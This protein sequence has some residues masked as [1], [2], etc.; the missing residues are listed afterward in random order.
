MF[1]N[2][3]GSKFPAAVLMMLAIAGVA[4]YAA[5]VFPVP[6][7][8]FIS[9][10]SA[11]P[12]GAQFTL[13]VNGANFVTSSTKSI[14]YWNGS[15]LVTRFVNSNQLT[16]VVPPGLIASG[17]TALVTVV[18][19]GCLG[20][21]SLS[22]NVVYL[23]IGAP[24]STL[25]VAA[26]SATVGSSPFE[27]TAADVNQDG[28]LDL[29]VS[30]LA[31][32]S[33]SILLGNG[34]GTFQPQT[35]FSTTVSGPF[36]IAIGDLNG[37]GIPDLVIGSD[38]TGLNIALGSAGGTYSVTS[39]SGG[40]CPLTPVLADVNHDGKLDIVVGNNCGNGIQVYFGNGDG[41][42][43][44]ATGISGSSQVSNLVVADLNG[45]GN[46]DVAAANFNLGTIDVYSGTG[47]GTFSPVSHVSAVSGARAIA[48]AD[49]DGDGK[50][51]LIVGSLTN[52]GI[53]FLHGNG[54]GTFQA[55]SS[56]VASGGFDSFAAGDMNTDGKMDFASVSA[57]G[58]VQAWLGNGDGTFQKPQTLGTGGGYGIALGNFAT[59]G[60]LSTAV[61]TGSGG[62]T[63][64]VYLQT[65]SLSPSSENFGSVNVG[66]SVQQIFTLTNSTS[67]T[68]GVSSVSF[69]GSDT[70]DFSQNNT[71][72]APLVPAAA[73]TVTVTFTPAAAGVRS[74]TLFISDS[75]PGSPQSASLS[76]TGV[77]VPL[78][79]LS[80]PLLMFGSQDLNV[81]SSPMPLS[82]SNTGTAA[83][84]GITISLTGTNVS[85]FAQTNNCPNSL[86]ASASCTVNVT[87]TPSAAGACSATL[88][89]TDNAANS[90]QTA[91]LNGTGAL[92]AAQLQFVQG[93]P[94]S[95]I[96]GS[97]IGML[98]VGVYTAQSMLATTSTAN[99][100]VTVTGP[101]SFHSSQTQATSS[102]V[103]AFNFNSPLTIAGQY[104]I[105]AISSELSSV[106]AN[107]T[108][109][110]QQSSAQMNVT[111]FPSPT[112]SG[113]P[114][115]FT[116]S[117]T[118]QFLNPITSYTGTMTLSSTDPSSILTPS[119][120]SFVAA[121]LGAH[122]FTGTLFTLGTQVI[123]ATDGQ[124]N[125]AQAG[126]QVN[127]RPQFVINTL[128]DDAGTA[129][130]DGNEPCSLR[131]AIAQSN[132]LGAGDI[133]VDTSQF[134]GALPFTSTLTNGVL[135]L[136]S[137]INITGPGETQ[138]VI[139]GKNA[140]NVFLVDVSAIATISSLTVTQGKSAGNGGA[141]SN[142]GTLA[143]SNV[144]VTNSAAAASGGG[145]YNSGNLTVSSSTISGNSAALN[146]GG[147][148]NGGTLAFYDSTISA[149]S[150]AGNGGGIDTSGTLSVPQSTFAANTAVDGAAIENEPTGLFTL[151]QS[152]L[153]GNTA[154]GNTG[155]SVS[156]QNST[157]G[158]ATIFE[159]IIAGNTAGGGDCLNCGTQSNFNLFGVIAATLN[160]APL[161]GNGGPTPTMVPLPGSP[162]IGAGSIE[163][164]QNPGVPQS[165][166]SDQ[167]GQ[168]FSRVVNNSVDLGAVQS[169]AGP[170]GSLALAAA[171]SSVA[172]QPLSV[173]AN[174]LTPSGNPAALFTDTVH[175]TS[176]D[177]HAVLPA[178]YTFT[179]ADS[180]SHL[181]SFTL[182]TSGPQ[183]V[184]ITDLQNNSLTSTQP[185]A[186]FP[187]APSAIAA[188]AGSGQS[189][190]TGAIFPVALQAKIT[191][192]FGN[193]VPAISVVF[194]APASGTSGTFLNSG[195]SVTVA[196]ADNGVAT[197]PAFTA[198]ST[199][200]QYTVAASSAALTPVTF[201]LTNVRASQPTYTVTANPSS[202]T[203]IQGQS[204]R[205]VLTFT[206][207]GR[208][209]GTISLSCTGLPASSNCVFVPAQTVLTGN[210]QPVTVALTVNTTGTSGQLSRFCPQTGRSPRQPNSRFVALLGMLLAVA[211]FAW[212]HPRNHRPRCS[213]AIQVLLIVLA[214][215]GLS[216]CGIASTGS[217]PQQGT[218][219]GTY[220]VN[221]VAAAGGG[222]Q[223]AAVTITIVSK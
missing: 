89:F 129:L 11:A 182:A 112:Y 163:L 14:V 139:S 25:T 103:A 98:S 84:T 91:S 10:I 66:S 171:S 58:F 149:N 172:G 42:F 33:V 183:T 82:L 167:R 121:D 62:A 135:E 9:P 138:L 220:S 45:D 115:A 19:P 123:S 203:I 29:L 79:T 60:G 193:G 12:G 147:I 160:L 181:F 49:F 122:N 125:G 88:Q 7:I 38:S 164:A 99:V 15:P 132:A 223:S 71:C 13:T 26:L 74:A 108:V 127:Q 39:L 206:P 136:S 146:G 105:S 78:A 180:G 144:A 4:V 53:V 192:A 2:V 31:A 188:T 199:T 50:L 207:A 209:S 56:I 24:V 120:Y 6:I 69:T 165:L 90:P 8:T 46:L 185:I 55:P 198:N 218:I 95:L 52:G 157:A 18:G 179:P 195:A 142:A 80:A 77:P 114:H 178:D 16:A 161:A 175:F 100:T 212:R 213:F 85:D 211:A 116:V 187:A 70:G 93:P 59:A 96:A 76:G 111:G 196:T 202:L 1:A 102:G 214:G 67:S 68:V 200:G 215:A 190:A 51:D 152:T 159:T 104:A 173:T 137:S 3:R 150:A 28:K 148:S 37:D 158:A 21:C 151:I 140:S 130:C 36:G 17:G 22:S 47:S 5:A 145:I 119:S 109:T 83:L 217:T 208:F 189:A 101:N 117:I 65:V 34:D 97:S 81:P 118:D 201:A 222:S 57:S 156:N 23:P 221:V 54:D 32:N 27:L 176:S 64:N 94:A 204:G 113:M 154:T 177:P 20:T 43:Q 153:S 155:A 194:T 197:A 72:S 63:I 191:D 40:S 141:I 106:A 107:L 219:P 168:N 205:S 133:T 87:F 131:S 186:V 35:T 128:A 184:S 174:A 169:N 86:A 124:L 61:S 210:N 143:L 166:A 216:A 75:A 126:I 41:T 73:C 30:N 134:T 44:A 170:A 92:A 110:V 162:A 48:A